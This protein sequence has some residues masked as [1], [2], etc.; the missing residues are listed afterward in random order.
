MEYP[1][2]IALVEDDVVLGEL[3]RE[4]LVSHNYRVDHALSGPDGVELILKLQPD[5]VIIDLLLPGYDGLE[6]CKR[7]RPAYSG[8]IIIL[9][10]SRS[11]A[12]HIRSLEGDADDFIIKP[13]DSRVLLARIRNVLKRSEPIGSISD[14]QDASSHM[15]TFGVLGLY[16]WK[17]EVYY[18]KILLPLTSVEYQILSALIMA[19]GE[20][21]T[22][23]RLFNDILGLEYDGLNRGL[24]VHISRIRKKLIVAGG[25]KSRIKSIRGEGYLLLP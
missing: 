24:D 2:H 16:A 17:R 12:D 10:A 25:D 3:T 20:V 9:T 14:D 5:L 15:I 13:L 4:Y 22:R 19:Q 23:D 1:A 8:P 18:D 11:D 21:I 6:V 7:I